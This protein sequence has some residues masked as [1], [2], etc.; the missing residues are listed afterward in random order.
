VFQKRRHETHGSSS[1]SSQP[2]FD[3]F[4]SDSPENLQQFLLKISPHFICV[5]TLPCEILMSENERQSQTNAVIN[6]KIQGIT[7]VTCLRCECG[8]IFNSL[9]KKCLLLSL[10][11]K[12]VLKSVNIL[13]RH[14]QNGGL[15]RALSSTFSSVV[16]RRTKCTRQPILIW[17][18]TTSPHLKFAATLPCNLSSIAYFMTLMFHKVVW[19]H[20][21][22]VVGHL[23][24]F[25]A[26]LLENQLVKEF[27]KSVKN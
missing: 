1:L 25:T 8:G 12:K 13:C 22:R 14:G 20:V 23:V 19:Q 27:G 16:V 7:V 18:L 4:T 24:I 9:I 15:C 26:N 2:I 11:V 3:F 21:L 5:A 17:L 6:D 10:P